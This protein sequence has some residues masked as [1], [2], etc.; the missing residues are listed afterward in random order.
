MGK[1]DEIEEGNNFSKKESKIQEEKEKENSC[2]NEITCRTELDY[3]LFL[4]IEEIEQL[5]SCKKF[6]EANTLQVKISELE[7][8]KIKFPSLKEL[9]H[10]LSNPEEEMKQI[11]T[12]K[13]FSKADHV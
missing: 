6:N 10:Q 2:L 5:I 4:L 3:E 1:Q 7:N 8:L 11:I 13:E 12:K 9:Q